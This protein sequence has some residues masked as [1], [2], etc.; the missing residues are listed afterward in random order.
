MTGPQTT[1]PGWRM[2]RL[3]LLPFALVYAMAI[4]C[5]NAAY[6][7]HV[8]KPRRL[9]WPVV[10]VGNLSVGGAGKTP[11]VLLLADLLARRGWCVDVLSRG[12]GRKD[13]RARRVE[14]SEASTSQEFGDEP[15]M[16]ARRGLDVFVAADRY[17]AGLLAEAQTES[18]TARESAT[19]TIHLLD[20]GFQHRKLDRTVNI[21]LLR[22]SDLQDDVLPMGRLRE[23]LYA[24][25]RADIC[26]LRAEEANIRDRVLQLMGQTDPARVWLVERQTTLAGIADGVQRSGAVAFCGIADPGGFFA[27]LRRAGVSLQAQRQFADHHEY[28]AQDVESLLALVEK[29]GATCLITTEKDTM[30]LPPRLRAALSERCPLLIAGLDLKLREEAHAMA[31]LEA[32]LRRPRAGK[33][34]PEQG[35]MR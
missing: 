10:V 23:P 19:K 26:V 17:Q 32:L 3:L 29:S 16:L 14:A 35:D 22:A 33:I 21:L 4:R 11:M 30:R 1:R 2:L 31:T 20:D 6:D 5:K 24:L 13:A 28:T 7:F 18:G 34:Q 25:E 9:S 12:Y 8:L 15:L 27:G